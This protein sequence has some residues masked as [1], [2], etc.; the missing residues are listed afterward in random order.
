M[1]DTAPTIL[2]FRRDL[3]LDDN[4]ALAAAVERGGPVVPVFILDDEDAGD[5]RPGGASRRRCP[6][7]GA[8]T[9]SYSVLSSLWL[10]SAFS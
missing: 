5:W 6:H 8:Q 4:P 1:P 10:Y 3:R 9:T 2:W 7:G